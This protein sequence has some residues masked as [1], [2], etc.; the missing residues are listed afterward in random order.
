MNRP[1]SRCKRVF[2]DTAVYFY[3]LKADKRGLKSECKIC[4]NLRTNVA[5]KKPFK[6]DETNKAFTDEII[7]YLNQNSM[8]ERSLSNLLQIAPN[9]IN[10]LCTGRRGL[11]LSSACYIANKIGIDLSKIQKQVK[12]DK[13]LP[14][15]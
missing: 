10:L 12:H 2:P 3:R 11:S 6:R 9:Y 14:K 15:E 13:Q 7:K 4:S 1:C 5:S 8:S